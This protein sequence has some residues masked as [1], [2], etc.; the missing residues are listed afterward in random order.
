MHLDGVLFH[1]AD[2]GRF[3][4][5]LRQASVPFVHIASMF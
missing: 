2:I 1:I 5:D 4:K 3:H